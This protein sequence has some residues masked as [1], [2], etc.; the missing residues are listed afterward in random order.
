MR[1]FE[2]KIA[3]PGS[4]GKVVYVAAKDGKV[5]EK[6][7]KDNSIQDDCVITETDYTEES[8]KAEGKDLAEKIEDPEAKDR[9]KKKSS[10]KEELKTHGYKRIKL[11]SY[12]MG[13]SVITK[14]GADH[15]WYGDLVGNHGLYYLAINSLDKDETKIIDMISVISTNIE[16]WWEVED[17]V[18]S[19]SA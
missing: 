11:L 1:V 6:W 5:M 10:L 19:P 16:V 14:D 17:E 8:L 3:L 9:E 4:E 2:V 7:A 13:P 12:V 15:Q 18:Q